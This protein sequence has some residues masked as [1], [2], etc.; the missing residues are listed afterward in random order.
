MI[1]FENDYDIEELENR[2][3][4]TYN[5]TQDNWQVERGA[6][7]D[8]NYIDHNDNNKVK[9]KE[10]VIYEWGA[11][12]RFPLNLHKR[13]S[14]YNNQGDLIHSKDVIKKQISVTKLAEIKES[15]ARRRIKYLEGAANNLRALADALPTELPN[16]GVIQAQYHQV[17]DNIDLLFEHYRIEIQDYRERQTN[18][19]E[20]AV[21]NEINPQI[22]AILN[23]P[24]RQPDTDFP[25]GLTVKQSIIYQLTGVKP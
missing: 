15:I 5:L 25:N 23:I 1:D 4:A 7:T 19:F 8:K 11:D 13:L 3:L 9:A 21:L 16:V 18:S 2:I 10:S 22:L 20:E 6:N 17:A 24:A 14:W 12:A